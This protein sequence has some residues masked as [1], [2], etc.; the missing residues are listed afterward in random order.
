MKERN[1]ALGLITSRERGD[2]ISLIDSTFS[3]GPVDADSC[4]NCAGDDRNLAA[5]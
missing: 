5:A 3:S 2:M 1:V 4:S